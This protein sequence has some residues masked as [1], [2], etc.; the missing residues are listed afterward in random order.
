MADEVTPW[1]AW[2]RYPL[3]AALAVVVVVGLVLAVTSGVDSAVWRI[4]IAAVVI[5]ALLAPVQLWG[6]R[7]RSH[8]S[9]LHLAEDLDRL[10][11]RIAE[12]RE[13][14]PAR[15][16]SGA[17]DQSLITAADAVAVARNRLAAGEERD[18]AERVEAMSLPWAGDLGEQL[19]RCRATA[20]T[21][22][23]SGRRADRLRR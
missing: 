15:R 17:D 8:R 22:A 3:I 20:R 12:E 5:P 4:L 23:R 21:L 16:T 6:V 13:V 14:E 19:A 11:A 10:R 18:A 2:V 1:P 7:R 9:A